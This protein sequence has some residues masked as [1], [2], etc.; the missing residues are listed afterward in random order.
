MSPLRRSKCGVPAD[1]NDLQEISYHPRHG[2]RKQWRLSAR[3]YPK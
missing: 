1:A 2:C 3:L